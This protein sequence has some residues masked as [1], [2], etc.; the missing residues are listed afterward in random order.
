MKP[1][2]GCEQVPEHSLCHYKHDKDDIDD[3]NYK[4]DKDDIETR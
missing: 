3:K 1:I 4:Y 2:S